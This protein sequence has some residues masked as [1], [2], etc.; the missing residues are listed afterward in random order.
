[1]R[2]NGKAQATHLK[3]EG[4]S[5]YGSRLRLQN[6][7]RLLIETNELLCAWHVE[8]GAADWIFYSCP[9]RL[10]PSVFETTPAPPFEKDGPL[11]RI[12]RDVPR[13][14]VDVL[15]RTYK[16]LQYGQ[17]EEAPERG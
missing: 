14:T 17:I 2:G 12:P 10:W 5:R 13:P 3:T 16:S 11:V 9:V 7:R 1:M 4:K 15:L 8:F 6:A